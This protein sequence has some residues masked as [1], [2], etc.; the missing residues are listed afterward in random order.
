L[1]LLI[2][3]PGWE[4]FENLT[5]KS[6]VMVNEDWPKDII[7]DLTGVFSYVGMESLRNRLKDRR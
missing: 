6:V 5:G 3:I 2:M 7:S 1:A 4:G